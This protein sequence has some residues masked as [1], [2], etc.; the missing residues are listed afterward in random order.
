MAPHRIGID[1]FWPFGKSSF[2]VFR[3]F[4]NFV[5]NV[6]LYWAGI[7]TSYIERHL[8]CFKAN[9][10]SALFPFTVH[11]LMHIFFFSFFA[12]SQ[13]DLHLIFYWHSFYLCFT[14]IQWIFPDGILLLL[15]IS[16]F[17]LLA[18][19]R[20]HCTCKIVYTCNFKS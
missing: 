13:L 16:I 6:A 5:F 2:F 19:N 3:Y 4:Y 10:K 12:K 7:D 20:S 9:H 1:S 11:F 8:L 18:E 17:L 15:A 14:Y